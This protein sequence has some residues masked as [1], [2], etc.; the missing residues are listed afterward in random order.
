LAASPINRLE[1]GLVRLAVRGTSALSKQVSK[2]P[3]PVMK[4]GKWKMENGKFL[5]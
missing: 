2:I 1:S 3:D 5:F 4:N